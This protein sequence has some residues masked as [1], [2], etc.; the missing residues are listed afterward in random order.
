MEDVE[1]AF[2][3]GQLCIQLEG[4]GDPAAERPDVLRAP[5]CVILVW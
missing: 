1:R 2:Y 4:H 5:E 3:A